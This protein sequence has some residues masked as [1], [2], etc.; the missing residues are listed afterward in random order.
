MQIKQ[1][2][3]IF[4]YLLSSLHFL[5]FHISMLHSQYIF[6]FY[7]PG[8]K[9]CLLFL[10]NLLP[11]TSVEICNFNYCFFHFRCYLVLFK[12]YEFL[13]LF[14]IF[15]ANVFKFITYFYY[16]LS[17]NALKDASETFYIWNLSLLTL[18]YVGS[19]SCYSVNFFHGPEIWI[20]CLPLYFK[21]YLG[22]FPEA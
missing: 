15:P 21:N 19:C 20:A 10:F 7:L 14:F 9:F 2:Q 1:I 11:Q 18:I 12:V 6:L 3:T 5:Y 4:I 17:M 13:F 8:H 22:A 16:T